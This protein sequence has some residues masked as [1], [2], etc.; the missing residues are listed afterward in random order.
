[1][2]RKEEYQKILRNLK[3]AG[4]L[5]NEAKYKVMQEEIFKMNEEQLQKLKREYKKLKL[6]KI[7]SEEDYDQ[8]MEYVMFISSSRS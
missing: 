8:F 6:E 1:M 4:F 7:K 2:G 3:K 5:T